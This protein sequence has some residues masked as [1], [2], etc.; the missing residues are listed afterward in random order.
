LS[1]ACSTTPIT[2]Q[3]GLQSE[4]LL[5]QLQKKNK[6]KQTNPLKSKQEAGEIIQWLRVL[7]VLPE[8]MSWVP[9]THIR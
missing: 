9:G 4:A 3:P 5:P 7:C 2:G 6:T 1:P 8:D